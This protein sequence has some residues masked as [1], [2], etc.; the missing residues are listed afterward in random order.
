LLGFAQEDAGGGFFFGESLLECERVGDLGDVGAAG[1]LAGFEDYAAP[2]FGAL[3]GGLGE[4]LFGAA[5]EDRS[6][7]RDA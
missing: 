1:L 3:E 7:L 2:A 5:G 4:M 6:D